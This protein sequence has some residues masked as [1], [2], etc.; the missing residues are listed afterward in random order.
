LRKIA[1]ELAEMGYLGP[2]EK[3]YGAESVKR[4]LRR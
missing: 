4:M 1:I 3:P 2:S